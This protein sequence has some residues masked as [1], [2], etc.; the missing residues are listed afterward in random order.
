MKGKSKR[1]FTTFTLFSILALLPMSCGLFCGSDSCGCGPVPKPREFV[2]ESFATK[3][4][5]GYGNE[6]PET[7]SR[8]YNQIFKSI[9]IKDIK[10]LSAIKVE[11]PTPWSLGF[12]LACSPA[13]DTSKNKLQL[14]QIINESE[15][16]LADGREFGVGE[17]LN[18]LFGIGHVFQTNL[19][20]IQEFTR[21]G[22]NLNFDDFYKI[23]LLQN[24]EKELQLKFTIQLV[25]D[26]AQEFLLSDQ[27]LTIR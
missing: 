18:S 8:N 9:E 17:N 7:Q 26:D 13:P 2:I 1:I 24:P 5:D 23:G 21:L 4:V 20:P 10:Y 25:F 19:V 14:I 6:I 15:F 27:I 11:E 16:T 3:T 22:S 12:A